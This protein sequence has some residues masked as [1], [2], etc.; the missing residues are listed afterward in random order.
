MQEQ[1]YNKRTI[2]TP[3]SSTKGNVESQQN[4]KLQTKKIIPKKKKRRNG[5]FTRIL[6][7]GEFDFLYD[8]TITPIHIG[9]QML[10]TEIALINAKFKLLAQKNE[11][12]FN[13]MIERDIIRII[14]KVKQLF[15]YLN[16]L[17]NAL[18]KY[19][20]ILNRQVSDWKSIKKIKYDPKDNLFS[21]KLLCQKFIV[22]KPDDNQGSNMFANFLK[23]NKE[24][25]IVMP[26]KSLVDIKK[27]DTENEL[28]IKSNRKSL[29]PRR[30]SHC[31][32][33]NKNVSD[34]FE[35]DFTSNKGLSQKEI[36]LE[37][38]YI[39]TPQMN[40]SPKKTGI[41]G[42]V[43]DNEKKSPKENLGTVVNVFNGNKN[44]QDQQKSSEASEPDFEPIKQ[45]FFYDEFFYY[46][47]DS[48]L[49]TS[50][51][52]KKLKFHKR[53]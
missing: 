42:I 14:N 13:N 3:E 36:N 2:S 24:K 37:T 12:V 29:T 20:F 4:S 52:Y 50:L 43:T 44:N 38:P 32:I 1:T 7:K 11:T 39:K 8:E 9:I 33:I 22:T 26:T 51:I 28:E 46:L 6:K 35:K 23:P 16:R 27:I 15:E 31:E 34:C 21:L 53:S 25:N 10:R 41:F 18:H 45:K 47:L 5:L 48:Y 30:K 40:L 17:H 49:N 19:T